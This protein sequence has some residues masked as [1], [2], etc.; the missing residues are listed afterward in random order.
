M[1]VLLL[2][3][4]EFERLLFDKL[5][6]YLKKYL[7]SFLCGFLKASSIEHALFKLLPAWQEEPDKIVFLGII[8][9]DLSKAY[10]CLPHHI[11]VAK[12]EVSGIGKA[13][14]NL[15]HSY[16]V[17]IHEKRLYTLSTEKYLGV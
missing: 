15:I 17:S 10:D 12:L 11:L 9:A 5:S 7:F 2:L 3:T 14:L 13:S 16:E 1:S 6:K 8:L 4:K